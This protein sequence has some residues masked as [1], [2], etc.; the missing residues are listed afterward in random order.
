MNGDL[1]HLTV[2]EAKNFSMKAAI[3]AQAVLRLVSLGFL[4]GLT[5]SCVFCMPIEAIEATEDCRI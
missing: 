2:F 1:Y 3:A 5:G 4:A